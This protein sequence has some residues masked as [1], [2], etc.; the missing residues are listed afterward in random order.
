MA[1]SDSLKGVRPSSPKTNLAAVNWRE[2]V[3]RERHFPFYKLKQLDSSGIRT[4]T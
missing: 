1:S 2:L 3:S 4:H